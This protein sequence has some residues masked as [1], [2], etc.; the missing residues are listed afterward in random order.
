M[1]QEPVDFG[2]LLGNGA[3]R[4][5]LLELAN[6]LI[7]R[8]EFTLAAIYNLIDELLP[9]E[10]ADKMK[11][12]TRRCDEELTVKYLGAKDVK[13]LELKGS[14][15]KKICFFLFQTILGNDGVLLYHSAIQTAPFHYSL[16]V[17][18]YNFSYWAL[19]NVLNVPATQVRFSL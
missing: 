5:P 18:I 19:F 14:N 4:N 12:L 16:L 11:E 9:K 6:K 1:T 3:K 2:Q 15:K 8:S 10:N 7:G 13:Y 17:N